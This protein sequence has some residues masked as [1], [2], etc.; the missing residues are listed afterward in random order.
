[1][2]IL[3]AKDVKFFLFCFFLVF[4]VFFLC[5][6]SFLCRQRIFCSECEDTQAVLSLRW[7]YMSDGMFS[8]VTAKK[9]LKCT[10][11]SC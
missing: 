4:V 7:A 3:I 11:L 5:V 6:F 1:M 2:R 8:R 9:F 10:L